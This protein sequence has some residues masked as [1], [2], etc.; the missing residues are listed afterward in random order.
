[1]CPLGAWNAGPAPAGAAGTKPGMGAAGLA[2]DQRVDAPAGDEPDLLE[3]GA[4]LDVR[5]A[6]GARTQRLED[7]LPG[8]AA[9]GD[10]EGEAVALAVGAVQALHL[11]QFLA[12]ERVQPGAA[13]LAGGFGGHRAGLRLAAGQ[14]RVAAQE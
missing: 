8:V 14:L 3:R 10:D 7:L 11:V 13:L 2:A 5:A 4:A 9:H 12:A 6:R 1:M